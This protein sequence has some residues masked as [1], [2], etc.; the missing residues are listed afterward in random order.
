MTQLD[1]SRVFLDTNVFLIA[2]DS[3]R[4]QRR[5]ALFALEQ[6]PSLGT[7]T[8]TS[9]QVMREYLVVAT[10]PTKANGLGLA[11]DQ[12]MANVEQ[13]GHAVTL[14]TETTKTWNQLCALLGSSQLTGTRIHDANIAACALANGVSAL[15]TAN[16]A[17]FAKLPLTVIDLVSLG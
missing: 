7:R 12:A 15:L 10:R 5:S 13:F 1:P 9:T 4:Q 17:D 3:S 16:T 11:L 2:T 6:W 14:L 8:Y